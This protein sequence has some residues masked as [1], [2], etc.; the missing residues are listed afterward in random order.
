MTVEATRTDAP[1]PVAGASR[2][3]NRTKVR[4]EWAGR[5]LMAPAVFHVLFW[6]GVPIIW[7]FVLSFTDYDVVRPPLFIG[8]DNY[9]ELLT[10]PLFWKAVANN[11][12]MTIVGVPIGIFISLVLA[13]LLNQGRRGQGD[14]PGSSLSQTLSCD[15]TSPNSFHVPLVKRASRT[16]WRG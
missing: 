7:S 3:R 16:A 6:I 4:Q 15:R 14:G 5:L 12:L 10:S 11:T 9:A 2:R 13:V 8:L 1:A